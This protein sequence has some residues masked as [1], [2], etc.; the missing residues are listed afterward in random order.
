MDGEG[1]AGER[2][3]IGDKSTF[4]SPDAQIGARDPGFGI[5]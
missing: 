1:S 2:A 4:E 3:V 5:G